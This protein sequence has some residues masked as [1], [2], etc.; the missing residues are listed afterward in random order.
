MFQ[1]FEL[2]CQQSGTGATA[3]GL[4]GRRAG[5]PHSGQVSESEFRRSRNAPIYDHA[6]HLW[7]Y[8]TGP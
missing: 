8:I 2:L 3:Y 5:A 6:H 4:T 7:D 1:P